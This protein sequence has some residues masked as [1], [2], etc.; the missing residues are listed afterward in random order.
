MYQAAILRRHVR[1]FQGASNKAIDL[2]S[3][4]VTQLA[5]LAFAGTVTALA[6]WLA[7][8]GS[9]WVAFLGAD[10]VGRLA[11]LTP[12]Y[13]SQIWIALVGSGLY[14][15]VSLARLRQRLRR[16]ERRASDRVAA[17]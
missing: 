8:R 10:S 15:S 11:T 12:V 4:A 16:P 17:I 9:L 3:T 6:I 14:A 13:D 2:L 1:V 7:Q 5:V